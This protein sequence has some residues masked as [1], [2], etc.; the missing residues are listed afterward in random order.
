[1]GTITDR[2]MIDETALLSHIQSG[3]VGSEIWK[4][5]IEGREGGGHLKLT[6]VSANSVSFL[7]LYQMETKCWNTID[8][9]RNLERWALFIL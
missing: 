2:L 1:M 9:E 6:V 8:E 4:G 5:Q 3:V 7:I